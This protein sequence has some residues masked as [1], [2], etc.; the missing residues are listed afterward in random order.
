[1]KT[2]RTTE[3]LSRQAEMLSG[4]H[5]PKSQDARHAAMTEWEKENRGGYMLHAQAEMTQPNN[6]NLKLNPL[7]S[8]RDGSQYLGDWMIA[9]A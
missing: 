7:F 9:S 8:L 2:G 5:T 4:W 6:T 3:Y 1:M